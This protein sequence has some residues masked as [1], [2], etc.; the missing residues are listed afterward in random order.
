MVPSLTSMYQIVRSKET[1]LF[2]ICIFFLEEEVWRNHWNKFFLLFALL[3]P[4]P[5][6]LTVC[7]SLFRPNACT[8]FHREPQFYNFFLSQT[9]HTSKMHFVLRW[10]CNAFLFTLARSFVCRWHNARNDKKNSRGRFQCGVTT[11]LTSRARKVKLTCLPEDTPKKDNE[12]NRHSSLALSLI[13][14]A[15][16]TNV[17]KMELFPLPFGCWAGADRA[18]SSFAAFSLFFLHFHRDARVKRRRGRQSE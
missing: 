17:C 1:Y 16:N 8:K 5:A 15:T 6:A 3:M 2:Y 13:R 14:H 12:R 10:F 18:R 11:T 9:L 4:W 7:V